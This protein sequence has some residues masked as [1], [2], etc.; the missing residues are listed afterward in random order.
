MWTILTGVHTLTCLF[1][2]TPLAATA[3]CPRPANVYQNLLV[4][5]E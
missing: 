2:L 3:A 5:I 1:T 4:P